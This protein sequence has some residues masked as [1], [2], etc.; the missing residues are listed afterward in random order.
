MLYIAPLEGLVKF[1]KSANSIEGWR[2]RALVPVS[3]DF[4]DPPRSLAPYKAPVEGPPEASLVE[5]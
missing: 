3:P 2:I 1:N 4:L 5:N